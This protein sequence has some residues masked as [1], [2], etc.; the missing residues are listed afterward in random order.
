MT[1]RYL[2]YEAKAT[3]VAAGGTLR[4]AGH[5]ADV[6]V[7]QRADRIALHSISL[8]HNAGCL[9]EHVPIHRRGPPVLW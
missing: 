1:T 4:L 9:H 5:M 7:E 3:A 8:E 6:L 2:P